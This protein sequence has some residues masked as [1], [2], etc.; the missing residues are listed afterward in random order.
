MGHL[1]LK[2]SVAL[3]VVSS[4][5]RAQFS[6]LAVT[7]DGSQVYFVTGL[8]LVSEASQNPPYGNLIYRIANGLIERVTAPP[9]DSP[10]PFHFYSLGNPQVSAD[11]SVFLYTRYTYCDGGSA[12][13]FYPSTSTSF[14]EVG[15]QPDVV[16]I[17]DL[18][19]GTTVPLPLPPAGR[20]Q[21]VTSGGTALLMNPLKPGGHRSR[22]WRFGRCRK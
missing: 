13:I 3:L 19:T 15:G 9:G 12:C 21:A 20:R 10:E 17:Y 4:C 8:R 6:D 5:A 1:R 7:D 2:L 11:G 16:Q 22:R 18:Q 14:L